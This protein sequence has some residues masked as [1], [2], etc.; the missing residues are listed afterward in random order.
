VTPAEESAEAQAEAP[1]TPETAPTEATPPATAPA[2]TPA[3]AAETSSS[4]Q[5]H[6]V[7]R[8][9]SLWK[10]A[11]A[12]YGDGAMWTKIAEANALRNPNLLTVGQELELPAR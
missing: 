11:E 8:G 3:P 6:T 1:A 2:E 4:A 5:T 9:E 10:I 12:V 7:A